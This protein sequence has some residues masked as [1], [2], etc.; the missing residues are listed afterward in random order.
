MPIYNGGGGVA[1][2]TV[3]EDPSA[4]KMAQNL[5]DLQNVGAARTN[6]DVYSTGGADSAISSAISGISIPAVNPV[7]TLDDMNNSYTASPAS[8]KNGTISCFGAS[9]YNIYIDANQGW[10]VGDRFCIAVA[11]NASQ[12]YVN[13]VTDG[14][15]QYNYLNGN[16]QHTINQ[17]TV[18]WVVYQGYYVNDG[19]YNHYWAIG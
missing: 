7:V 8:V 3:E 19:T 2:I 18:H 11:S 5:A 9:A 14:S 15:S 6:L 16:T 13:G 17:P 4:L 10:Q 1:G 12:V